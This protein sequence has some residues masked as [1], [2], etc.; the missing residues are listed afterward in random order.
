MSLSLSVLTYLLLSLSAQIK[1]ISLSHTQFHFYIRLYKYSV[2]L[3]QQS[4]KCLKL[5][6][7]RRQN[8]RKYPPTQRGKG[9]SYV[10]EGEYVRKLK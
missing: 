6:E 1:V 10:A 4:G 2:I 5:I 9:W 7:M 3:C 8:N